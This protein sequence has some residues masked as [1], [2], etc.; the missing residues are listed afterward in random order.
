MTHQT[1]PAIDPRVCPICGAPNQ[2][3]MA[4]TSKPTGQTT[5]RLNEI[6][7]PDLPCWCFS[8]VFSGDLL[9]RVPDEAKN[10]SCVCP[11]CV[12]AYS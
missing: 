6:N 1:P 2:C 11:S 10:L 3:V 12:T 5:D 7:S 8:M 4:N 9:S